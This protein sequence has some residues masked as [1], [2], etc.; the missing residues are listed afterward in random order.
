[1][2]K[3]EHHN[4]R[5]EQKRFLTEVSG[6]AERKARARAERERGVWFWLGMM[7]LVGWSV[8]IPTLIGVFIGTWLDR[9]QPGR[10][11]W[12]ITFL[13]IGVT[14]GCLQAWYWVRRESRRE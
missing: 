13:L 3:N 4:G 14:V 6:K 7:G 11:S 8:M 2:P 10:V 12:T 5:D 9:A 1:M